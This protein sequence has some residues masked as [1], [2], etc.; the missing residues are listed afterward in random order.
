MRIKFVHL[1]LIAVFAA[2]CQSLDSKKATPQDPPSSQSQ[3][4][5]YTLDGKPLFP[6]PESETSLRK[7]DSLLQIARQ[8]YQM[9]STNLDNIIW[10]G[11]R[12]AY[13]SRFQEAIAIY[14]RGLE[15]HPNAAELYRH[16]GHRYLSIR[17][18][19]LAIADLEKAAALAKSRAI[20]IEPDG[21]PNKINKPLSS[22]QFNIWYHWALAYYL[23]GDFAKAASIYEACMAYS[24][25]PDLITAT[26]DWLYMTYRRLGKK[27]DA[28]K[29]L[30]KI[31]PG[32][33]IIENESYYNRL[34]MYK[35][36]KKPDELL[37]LEAPP[38]DTDILLNTVTQGYGVGNWYLYNGDTTKA[39]EIFQKV[40][41]TDYWIAFGYIAAEAELVR[42]K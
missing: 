8:N 31:K 1:L 19:D 26:S 6:S 14:T 10:L 39:I 37:N 2:H 25:N 11:R 33:E 12:T 32:M 42:M 22:L 16:R 28:T 20:E 34:M 9:D 38:K 29:V 5:A 15:K 4:E 41:A 23:K 30:D 13:L 18:F 3:P 27:E 17:Q 35:G 21:I 7:K 24:T 40:T 36:L